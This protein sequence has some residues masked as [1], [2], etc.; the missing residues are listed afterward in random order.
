MAVKEKA[1]AEEQERARVA[2][3]QITKDGKL[4][5]A[6][7]REQEEANKGLRIREQMRQKKEDEDY[8]QKLLDQVEN[9]KKARLGD[10]YRP[11]EKKAVTPIENV[12]LGI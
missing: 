4:M 7:A 9:E 3:I 12:R 10:K 11:P 2:S 6:A 1:L 5:T 8:M